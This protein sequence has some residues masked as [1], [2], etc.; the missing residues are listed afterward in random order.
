MSTWAAFWG[1]LAI[2][3]RLQL[4]D[5]GAR[6]HQ[7]VV[8]EDV[9]DVGAD[10]RDQVDLAQIGRRLGE[11]DAQRVAVDHQR[12]AAEVEAGE[13][14]LDELRLGLA[15][16]EILDDDQPA[17]LRLGGERHAEAESA[18]L[19]VQRRVEIADARAVGLA[20]ADEDRG[21]AV[22]VTGG[23]AALLA[24]IL[25]A[26]AGDV[27]PLAGGAG[28]AAALLELPG[29]DAVEDVGPRLDTEHLV[30]ELDVL[31]GLAAVETLN[32]DL[33]GLAFL[34]F[35]GFRSRSLFGGR[36]GGSLVVIL[37]GADAGRVRRGVR[38]GD[39]HRVLDQQPA[40]L[41]AGDR[42]LD[43]EEAA[44]D[45]GADDLEILLGAVLR[46]HVPGHLLVLEDAARILALAG[47]AER[48][49]RERHAVGGAK[50]AEAPALHAARKALALGHALDVDILAGDI[51]VGGELGA[52]VEESVLRDDELGD[53]RLR[54]HLG[55][56]EMAALR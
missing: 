27:R 50:T 20:A 31:A 14:L 43:E 28:G 35:G 21:A 32:F 49:V 37:G 53:P 22:A 9:V 3:T 38:A 24:T 48:A 26:G 17:V 52:D 33:H 2:E 42:A 12:L 11:A 40:A 13:P 39:L 45:V 25:L 44:L 6:Q 10:R 47:R 41:V 54:L 46:A 29:D 8:I 7:G 18:D 4:L 19:L 36:L 16:V 55:L 15:D 23:T 30:V 51:M 5:R 34:A 56:A 1:F